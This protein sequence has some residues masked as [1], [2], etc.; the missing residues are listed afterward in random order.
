MLG[1][2]WLRLLLSAFIAC[3]ISGAM[4][5]THSPRSVPHHLLKAPHIQQVADPVNASI[6]WFKRMISADVHTRIV[7]Q[8][9]EALE[10]LSW[11]R[12]QTGG[13]LL[14]HDGSTNDT[15]H[16]R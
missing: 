13:N 6:F 7:Q 1:C 9:S 2:C 15:P 16:N 10:L 4:Q 3:G 14:K 12:S 5:S 11:L 8:T